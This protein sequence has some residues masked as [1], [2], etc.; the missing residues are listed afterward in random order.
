MITHVLIHISRIKLVSELQKWLS[1][2]QLD[3]SNSTYSA[4]PISSS[5]SNCA[6][7]LHCV[8]CDINTCLVSQIRS[9][10]VLYGIS[11]ALILHAQL[12]SWPPPLCPHRQ[13]LACF[14]PSFANESSCLQSSSMIPKSVY[15]IANQVNFQK[16]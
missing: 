12:A 16:F 4:L 15:H 10:G 2:C 5:S 14:L 8:L 7:S 9:P 1:N 6:L 3:M 13:S 11:S